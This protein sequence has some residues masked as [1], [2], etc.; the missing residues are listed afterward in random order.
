MT[1]QKADKIVKEKL[2][3]EIAEY[4]NANFTELSDAQ[5][6]VADEGDIRCLLNMLAPSA[7]AAPMVGGAGWRMSDLE[8][9]LR[10]RDESFSESLLRMIDERGMTDSECYKRANISRQV[11]SKIRIHPDYKPS[12]QTAIAFAI[13]LKLTL[14]ETDAFLEKAGF[15]L[16]HS[17]KFD[18]IVEYF[19]QKEIYD[20]AVINEALF[21][22]DQPL[23]GV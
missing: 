19:I 9:S 15:S 14:D 20:I 2:Y 1:E 10:N 13:A 18:I 5:S 21:E 11:F 23:I 7:S 16:S 17:S 3:F 8:E 6:G 4:L 12:K 22:F